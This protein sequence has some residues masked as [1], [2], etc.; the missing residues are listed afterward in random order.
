MRCGDLNLGIKCIR[1]AIDHV[2]NDL[3]PSFISIIFTQ[4]LMLLV[5]LLLSN[6]EPKNGPLDKSLTS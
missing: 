2:S 6:S 4:L 5:K 3:K 1:H